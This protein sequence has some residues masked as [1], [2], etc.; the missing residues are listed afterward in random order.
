MTISGRKSGARTPQKPTKQRAIGWDVDPKEV[1]RLKAK[2]ERN[3]KAAGKVIISRNEAIEKGLVRYF[4]G[5][6]CAKGHLSEKYVAGY[7]CAAC[8]EEKRN[9]WRD[10]NR[11]RYNKSINDYCKACSKVDP[12]F[13]MALRVRTSVRDAINRGGFKKDSKTA[14][15]LGCSWLEFVVHIEKQFLPGMTWANK[16]LWQLDH[17]VAISEG[18]TVEEVLALSHFTNLRP[19]WTKDNLLKSDQKHF[20]I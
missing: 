9:A 20:L 5:E 8:V 14:Q 2:A 15:Y 6:L 11:A 19:L 1:R 3:A 10:A 12:A 4:T 16:S 13:A 18:K 7:R 17:I